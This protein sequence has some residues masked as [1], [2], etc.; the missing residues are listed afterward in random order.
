MFA[1]ELIAIK[2]RT[3]SNYIGKV[4]TMSMKAS[5]LCLFQLVMVE[6]KIIVVP[7][8]AVKIA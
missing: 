7:T 8:I 4:I 5:H 6:H 3:N 1:E 2:K